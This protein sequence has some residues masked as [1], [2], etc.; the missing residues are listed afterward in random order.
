MS[1]SIAFADHNNDLLK[2]ALCVGGTFDLNAGYYL[3]GKYGEMILNGALGYNTV[4]VGEANTYKTA[5]MLFFLLMGYRA[6]SWISDFDDKYATSV[7]IMET[8]NT[9]DGRRM[10][11]LSNLPW[12]ASGGS[13]DFMSDVRVL[14]NY[15]IFGED[16]ERQLRDYLRAKK[17]E[18]KLVEYPFLNRDGTLFKQLVPSFSGLDSLSYLK[19][20]AQDKREDKYEVTSSARNMQA[21]EG[22]RHKDLFIS[23]MNGLTG[24][25]RNYFVATAHIKDKLNL[26]NKPIEKKMQH[27]PQGKVLHQCPDSALRLPTGFWYVT[28]SEALL[29]SSRTEVLFPRDNEKRDRKTNVDLNLLTIKNCRGKAGPSGEPLYVIVS[30]TQGVL[31]SLTEFYNLYRN[32]RFGLT[33][34][35]DWYVADLKPDVKLCLTNIRSNTERGSRLRT[36]L[37]V[38]SDILQL[39]QISAANGLYDDVLVEPKELYADL[40]QMGY[41]W[42]QLLDTRGWWTVYNDKHPI[43]YLST[44]DLLNMRKKRYKPYWL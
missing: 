7:N 21:V 40:K 34:G 2:P 5:L 18:N 22:G 16:Y 27:I 28:H 20:G 12:Y 43:P 29:D 10:E 38:Q 44:L 3:P 36:A 23:A 33:G 4:D 31:P 35:R 15:E 24:L 9:L 32:E 1:A 19:F 41:N 17:K 37:R 11:Q 30:Q 13:A 42:D 25:Y 14:N 26:T 39:S 8:E 6:I